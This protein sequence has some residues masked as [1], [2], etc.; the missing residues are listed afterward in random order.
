[1]AKGKNIPRFRRSSVVFRVE[2]NKQKPVLMKYTVETG[3][4]LS[5]VVKDTS[6]KEQIIVG[7]EML[8]QF[9]DS[10]DE[11]IGLEFARIATDVVKHG[12]D[13]RKCLQ[14][15]ALLGD[16]LGKKK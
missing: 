2:W 15:A 10:A 14:Q 3:S 9:S 1:M 16:L 13:A 12:K 4:V 7:R 5:I 6:G 11:A 8:R